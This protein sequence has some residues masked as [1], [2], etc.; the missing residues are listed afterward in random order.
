MSIIRRSSTAGGVAAALLGFVGV[1]WTTTAIAEEAPRRPPAPATDAAPSQAWEPIPSAKGTPSRSGASVLRPPAL[2]N[3]RADRISQQADE[4]LYLFSVSASQAAEAD[5]TFTDLVIA[6]PQ[7]APND[8][9]SY[10][11]IAVAAPDGRQIVD[12]GWTV[13]H[14]YG[15]GEPH[16]SVSHFVDG[17]GG[18]S[19]GCGSC[20]SARPSR[21]ATGCRSVG[22]SRSPCSIPTAPGRSGTTGRGSATS[23]TSCGTTASSA[24]ASSSGSQGY[25]LPVRL[26]AQTWVPARTRATSRRPGS[27]PC[28]T[29]TD[30]SRQ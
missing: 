24:P 22:P 13:S 26:P 19:N 18:C 28:S 29:P 9:D 30:R 3:R 6:K 8:V 11:A 10:A 12:V 17:A 15:D 16:L 4:G 5:G 1:V 23:P 21:R 7:L 27:G 20:S 14:V 2:S 25:S